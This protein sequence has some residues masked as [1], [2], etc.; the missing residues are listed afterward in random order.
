MWLSLVERCVRDA[1]TA[2]SNRAIP[3]TWVLRVCF[4]ANPFFMPNARRKKKESFP[5]K[6]SLFGA[7]ENPTAR[8]RP[9]IAS[10]TTDCGVS[11]SACM[12]SQM[13]GEL[14]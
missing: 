3:T 13:H 4:T 14:V 1:E 6:E 12:A 7:G 9:Q 5:Y 2:R 11:R 8:L 10:A